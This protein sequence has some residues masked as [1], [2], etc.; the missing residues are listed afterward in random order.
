[1]LV[2]VVIISKD[3]RALADTLDV[4]R[5]L[6]TD[7]ETEV[8][9][10]D[11]S[12]RRLD[13]IRASHREVTWVD[14]PPVQ[15]KRITIP[16][17]RNLGVRTARG[18]I[19]AFTDAGCVP[20]RDWLQRLV[21][22]ILAGREHVTAGRTDSARG[23]NLYDARRLDDGYLV[24]CPT[25]NM[26]FTRESFDEVGGFDE[27]FDYCS[28]SDFTWRLRAAGRP[29]RAVPAARLTHDWGGSRRQAKRAWFYGAGRA[30]LYLKHHDERRSLV[31]RDPI[32]A[33]YPL[34]LVGLPLTLIFPAY[35]LLLAVPLWRNR[36]R[37]PVVTV[38]DHLCYGAGA[39]AHV[40]RRR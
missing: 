38:M 9:V 12:A 7:V 24:E 33:A 20:D 10:V 1:M 32:L 14:F 27:S 30:K 25:L 37:Q 4:L 29:L 35:P 3:E 31:R 26:A 15:G 23:P 28:D 6:E 22:P 5:L 13:D 17:Q 21:E 40:V 2:S 36:H 16:E 8:V 34:F 39:L 18:E 11:A 19:I